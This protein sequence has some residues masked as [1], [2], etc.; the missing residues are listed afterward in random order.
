MVSSRNELTGWVCAKTRIVFTALVFAAL[1]LTCR[2][3]D[4]SSTG[5]GE[6]LSSAASSKGLDPTLRKP[7]G[8][9]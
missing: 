9:L 1:S 6:P 3:S 7:Q 8:F 5:S 2:S 4:R